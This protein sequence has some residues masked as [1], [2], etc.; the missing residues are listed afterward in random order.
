M[1]QQLWRDGDEISLRP[2][3]FEVLRYL[4]DHPAQL[5]TKAMM[6]DAVWPGVIVSDSMP[7][8]CVAELRKALDDDARI[9]RIIETVHRRGY[10]FIAPVTTTT[11]SRKKNLKSPLAP[12]NPRSMVGREMEL[13]RLQNSYA[14]VLEAQRLILFV[15]GEAGIGKTTVIEEFLDSIANDGTARVGR[16]QCVEQYGSGE[17]YMPVLEALSR[18]SHEDDGQQVIDVLHRFAPTWLTQMPELLT[19]EERARLQS[20]MQG[21]TQQRM[22][23]EMT[24]ALEALSAETPIVLLLED[25]HWSDFSTLELISA[26]ARRS[27]PARIMIVGTY[28]PVEILANHHPLRTMKQELELHDYCEELRLKPLSEENVVDYLARRLAGNGSRQFRTLAPVIHARTD[29]NPLFIVNMVDYLLNDAGLVVNSR[30]VSEAEWAERLRVHRLDALRNI[31]HMIERNFERLSPQEQAVLEGAAVAGAEFS[32]A[33]VAAALECPQNEI[34]AC[35]AHLSRREQ[36]LRAQGASQWPDG[37]VA[38]GFRFDHALYQEVLYGRLP[39]GHRTQLHRRIAVRE[40]AGYGE[41]AD[42]VATELAHHYGLASDNAK[43]IQYL[44]LGGNR[45]VARGALMEAEGSYR[46]ALARL[47]ALSQSPERDR[48]EL[49]LASALF[50]VLVI[51]RGYTTPDVLEMAARARGLAEKSGNLTQFELQEYATWAALY[52]SGDILNATGLADQMLE[53]ARRRE[54]SHVSLAL[55]HSAQVG[56]CFASGDLPGAEK[57]FVSFDALFK[58]G[59][60]SEF[61]GTVVMTVG[62]AS[63]VAWLMG[64]PAKALERSVKA[65]AVAEDS[66]VPFDLAF[67]RFFQAWLGRWL[68]EPERVEAAATQALA[69]GEHHGFKYVNDVARTMQGWARAQIGGAASGLLLIRQG[70]ASLEKA[71]A[72][73]GI[74]EILTIMA[75]AQALDG[76]L[77][78]ALDTIERALR[79]RPEELVYRPNILTCR[80]E[81]FSKVGRADLAESDFRDAITLA[82]QMSARALELR[83][84]IGLARLLA[85]QGLRENGRA[86]LADTYGW[87]TDGFD[88]ADLK[89]ARA[90]LDELSK[91]PGVVRPSDVSANSR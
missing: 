47:G 33:S 24:Q 80:A 90:L 53:L 3:T 64:H 15:T 5:V 86:I 27:E 21:I 25:L 43:A 37:T 54:G 50:R 22:L 40:E 76:A 35:C 82:Q 13:A 23:R 68:K 72:R 51:T 73:T 63:L 85:T 44:R 57:H 87:F 26:I 71:G 48:C 16:G 45:A 69:I 59:S 28:R 91:E 6:L 60:S 74:M 67:A 4:V 11:A 46:Q 66:K 34:E 89:D 36:F 32:A 31:R 78:D 17:P 12:E 55:A 77:T 61:P 81:L 8:T 2:K 14:Q 79:A 41:R 65:I 75:E 18:L 7:A 10:R 52:A 9:P 49:E 88:T 19:R 20:E 58:A 1:N 30:E 62:W 39:M 38:A 70:L 56:V 42:E 29:G 84:T 83:A